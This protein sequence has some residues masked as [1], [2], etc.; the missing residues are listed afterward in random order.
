[1]TE[2]QKA[3]KRIRDAEYRRRKKAEKI[4]AEKAAKKAVKKNA[5]KVAKKTATKT[6]KKAAPKIGYDPNSCR[7]VI[8]EKINLGVQSPEQAKQ[9]AALVRLLAVFFV[10]LCKGLD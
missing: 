7:S 6:T 10:S 2:E 5:P 3:K 1:M 4:K 8:V 9:F